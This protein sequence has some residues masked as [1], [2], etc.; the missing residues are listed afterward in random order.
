[1]DHDAFS[2]LI[3][4]TEGPLRAYIAGMGVGRALVDDIAQEAYLAVWRQGLPAEVDRLRWLKGIARHKAVDALRTQGGRRRQLVEAM[5]GSADGDEA[6]DA[7]DGER[8]TALRACLARLAGADR[9]LID[10]CYRDDRSSDEVAASMGL[11]G[12]AVRKRL[13]RLRDALAACV[14]RRLQAGAP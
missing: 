10:A 13:I 6:E 11:T 5:A 9:G 7:A 1:M 4:A 14:Q 12:S 3:V 8:L 2:A